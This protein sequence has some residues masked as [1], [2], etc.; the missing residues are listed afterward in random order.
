MESKTNLTELLKYIDP[1]DLEY[2]EW[3]HVGMGLKA[4]GYE[5]EVWER[6]SASDPRHV[7]GEC[8]EKWNTFNDSGITGAFIVL[9]AKEAGWTPESIRKLPWMIQGKD[10]YSPTFI[11]DES[12][13]TIIPDQG[14]VEEEDFQE[15]KKWNPIDDVIT[16]LT[17]LFDPE[18]FV[19]FA[20]KSRY[21]E[22]RHKYIP[23]DKGVYT[24]TA[25]QLID[26]L[27]TDKTIERAFGNYDKNAGAWIRFNPLDGSGVKNNNVTEYRYALVECDNMELGRQIA[28]MKELHLPIAVMVYSGGKSIHSIVKIEASSYQEYKSKVDYLYQICEKNGLS[29]D[30]QNKNP[31][32]LSR[33]PGVYRGD[34]KQFLIETDIGEESYEAW[35]EWIESETDNL[36][37]PETLEE[38]MANPLPLAD[39]LI[40]GVLRVGHKMLVSGP[41]K[42]GKS[43]A[44]IEL[45][46][47]IAEGMKWLGCKCKQGKV[48]YV[49]LEIDK[50]SCQHRF[51]A[52]YDA[53]G[54]DYGTHKENISVWSLRGN[55]TPMN[56]LVP[57][58][59][60][61]CKGKGYIA[62]IIDPIY[63]VL[64]GDENNASDMGK[65]CNEFDIIANELNASVIYCHHHSKGFQGQKKAIDRASGSGVFARDPD[66]VMDM[67]QLD[68]SAEINKIHTGWR[69]ECT[70]RE[71]ENIDP[72]N[73]W[74]EYPLHK[75]TDELDDARPEND[76][77]EQMKQRA[78]ANEHKKEVN[79]QRRKDELEQNTVKMSLT[80]DKILKED[81]AVMSN[82]LRKELGLDSRSLNKWLKNI[83]GYLAKDAPP[84]KPFEIIRDDS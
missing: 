41:S 26:A 81:G 53:L 69:V 21:I 78:A 23:N 63:K 73:V 2:S 20:M 74:F 56:D 46:V 28:M 3:I 67:T 6:W 16:Y 8:Y 43:F 65:F 15:P 25:G 36:P 57:K 42:A 84:G 29:L 55:S 80:F 76:F 35:R 44:L 45:A 83:P 60:R 11:W 68:L 62:V 17:V 61:R 48:M 64:T 54:M 71:F 33:L 9:K 77:S 13:D 7:D 14:W 82:R 30:K 72:I 27:K 4:E 39:E 52:V 40:A 66:A 70:L 22:E 38:I 37:D 32:R 12:D 58:L 75:V 5:P 1:S 34:H 49:N 24:V 59:L 18:E 19:G 79:E 47:A 31:S 51:M 10:K 50:A